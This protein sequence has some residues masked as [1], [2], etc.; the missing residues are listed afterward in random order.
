MGCIASESYSSTHFTMNSHSILT[1]ELPAV[2]KQVEYYAPSILGIRQLQKRKPSHSYRIVERRLRMTDEAMKILENGEQPDLDNIDDPKDVLERIGAGA[3]LLG[4]ELIVIA[5]LIADFRRSWRFFDER[6]ERCPHLTELAESVLRGAEDTAEL[7]AILERLESD[8]WRSFELNGE[9]TNDASRHLS[10]IRSRMK[11]VEQEAR[12]K[13]AAVASD[14]SLREYF[15]ESEVH[16]KGGRPVIPVKASFRDKVSGVV[17]DVSASGATLFIE[18]LHVAT[19]SAK[20]EDL[21][22]EEHKEILRIRTVLST[23]IQEKLAAI[24]RMPGVIGRVEAIFA[25]AQYGIERKG[26][27][28]I[29]DRQGVLDLRQI[30]HP[31]IG[32]DCIPMSIRLDE[33]T[34]TVLI[35]GPNTGGKTVALKNIGL[36]VL[37]TSCGIPILATQES[38]IPMFRDILVDIGDEQSIEQSLSTFSAHMANMIRIIDHVRV[39][40]RG[41]CLVLLDEMGAGTDPEEGQAL[42]SAI[43]EWLHEQGSDEARIVATSHFAG[44]KELAATTTGMVNARMEFD[45]TTLQP[46]YV[47]HMGTPGS[48]QAFPVAA[49]LGLGRE[50]LERAGHLLGPDRV[51]LQKL[52]ASIE[53]ERMRMKTREDELVSQKRKLEE[54]QRIFQQQTA[55]ERNEVRREREQFKR[56][57]AE[58]IE[59]SRRHLRLVRESE[60]IKSAQRLHVRLHKDLSTVAPGDDESD[61]LVENIPDIQDGQTVHVEGIGDGVVVSSKID[62]YSAMV[63]IRGFHVEVPLTRIQPLSSATSDYVIEDSGDYYI[64]DVGYELKLLGLR[65]EEAK[66]EL[67]NYLDK[68]VSSGLS[69]VRII[70]GYGRGVLKSVVHSMLRKHPLVRRFRP[71]R[72]EEGGTGATVV[73]LND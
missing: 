22:K 14:D 72:P 58:I 54:E 50:I 15:Q 32:N 24:Q 34:R 26:S 28:A 16:F 73:Y 30:R 66:S 59:Q 19:L 4:E 21:Q 68:A 25:S 47:L 33:T 44:L 11:K 40:E 45:P 13:A 51:H 10:Q 63:A 41:Y 18:P 38:R 37:M 12:A 70:H 9:I 29:V 2:I 36:A 5:A 57:A 35:T 43:L 71:G 60:D 6:R 64:E 61:D 7:V 46:T 17:R 42:G 65:A 23:R 53:Q 69:E 55:T 8:I 39:L 52:L 27:C 67:E 49:R 1:L 56:E 62:G 20:L 48:S 3:V 31:L